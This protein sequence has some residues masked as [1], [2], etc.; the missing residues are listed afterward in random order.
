M[1]VFRRRASPSFPEVCHSLAPRGLL[2]FAVPG[3]IRKSSHADQRGIK[4]ATRPTN[5]TR[6]GPNVARWS[7]RGLDRVGDSLK[8]EF[9]GTNCC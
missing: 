2:I 5:S 3:H 8:Y 9:G 4:K 7:R 6:E 1:V